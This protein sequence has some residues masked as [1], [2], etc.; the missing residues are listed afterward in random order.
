M[1]VSNEGDLV[2]ALNTI[3]VP[4]YEEGESCRNPVTSP[5]SPT[6]PTMPRW[7]PPWAMNQIELSLWAQ[8]NSRWPTY[9]Y[10]APLKN[11]GT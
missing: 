4:T 7:C 8:P 11:N 5:L 2:L 1:S 9:S 6:A 3:P 10:R